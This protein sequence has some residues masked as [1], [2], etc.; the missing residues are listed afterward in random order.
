MNRQQ[1]IREFHYGRYGTAQAW[2][3][4]VIEAVGIM[5]PGT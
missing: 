3:G 4:R 5:A 2:C 1:K